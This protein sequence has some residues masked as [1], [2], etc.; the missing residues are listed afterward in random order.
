MKKS[1]LAGI[2]TGLALAGLQLFR[3]MPV[4]AQDNVVKQFDAGFG[5]NSV[6][7]V[8]ASEDTEIAGPQAIYAGD[9]GEIYLLDQVNARVVGFD[10]K[11]PG[12]RTRS[13][14]LPED[15]EPTDL[16]VAKGSI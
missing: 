7:V 8:E 15:M 2:L 4:L 11:E 10:A 13:L 5:P 16:I 14:A 6:G 3:A 12:A 9:D 1:H